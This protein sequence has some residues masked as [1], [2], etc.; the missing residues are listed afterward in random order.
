MRF[1]LCLQMSC[2][3]RLLAFPPQPCVGYGFAAIICIC[4]DPRRYCGVYKVEGKFT[5][6][7]KL[8]QQTYNTPRYAT[9]VEAVKALDW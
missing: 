3:C 5:G 7:I 9:Y 6:R 1:P 8:D 4:D 2:H